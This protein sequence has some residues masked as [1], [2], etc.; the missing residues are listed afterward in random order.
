[1][2]ND[3]V[4]DVMRLGFTER[5]ATVYIALLQ[6]GAAGV[7]DIA[8]AANVSRA[9]TYDTLDALGKLGLVTAYTEKEQRRYS[10]EPPERLLS[11]LHLQRRELV[12]R[13]AHAE[14]LLPRLAAMH[15][16]HDAKPRIRYIEGVNGL[17]N[18]Q[19][20]YEVYDGDILQLVGYDAFCA[21]EERKMSEDHR[22]MLHRTPRRVRTM[23]VTDRP[24]PPPGPG[25][26]LRRVS[27]SL[28]QA[29]GEVTVWGDRA[30]LFSYQG[31]IIAVEVASPAIAGTLRAALELAWKA[32]EHL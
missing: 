16:T 32:T 4:R 19:R 12:M 10:A 14:R 28:V 6:Q 7:Q 11:V 29:M 3:M 27:P 31:G 5:E 25:A 1:M 24:L 2:M 15:T 21:L 23:L 20:E 18:M 8:Q 26:T 9:S 30:I 13:E 22:A 17:R